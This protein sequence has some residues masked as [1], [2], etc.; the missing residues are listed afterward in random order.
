MAVRYRDSDGHWR[1]DKRTTYRI[2]SHVWPN[3]ARNR[4]QQQSALHVF[5]PADDPCNV[6]IRLWVAP[7]ATLVTAPGALA[8][9]PV[10]DMNAP[11]APSSAIQDAIPSSRLGPIDMRWRNSPRQHNLAAPWWLRSDATV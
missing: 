1:T 7:L 10:L 3:N 4:Y 5:R 2:V 11:V 6:D 9:A 8:V